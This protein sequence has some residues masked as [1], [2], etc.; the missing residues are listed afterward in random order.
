MPN[1]ARKHNFAAL[2]QDQAHARQADYAQMLADLRA[3]LKKAP[4]TPDVVARLNRLLAQLTGFPVVLA[5]HRINDH[6]QAQ[7]APYLYQVGAAH[8]DMGHFVQAEPYLAQALGQEPDNPELNAQMGICLAGQRRPGDAIRYF[9]AGLAQM[10]DN[11]SWHH[12]LGLCYLEDSQT[13]QATLHILRAIHL[14]L[15]NPSYHLSLTLVFVAS[16]VE[17]ALID[18]C[19]HNALRAA[20]TTTQL[21]H[22]QN[23]V[24]TLARRYREQGFEHLAKWLDYKRPDLAD[25]RERLRRLAKRQ[26]VELTPA[27][28]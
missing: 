7:N 17:G 16:K 3:D 25:D 6:A 18:E 23:R 28:V 27:A 4:H 2:F 11:A 19:Y 14:D 15:R 26:I 9:K 8:C 24:N 12:R 22:L 10:P 13:H 20:E 21:Q 5:E 1:T